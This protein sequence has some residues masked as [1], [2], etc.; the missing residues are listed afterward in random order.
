MRIKFKDYIVRE[1][2][3]AIRIPSDVEYWKKK[4]KRG[5]DCIIFTH[6]D[7]DGIYSAIAM[8]E[9]LLNHGFKISGFGVID[10]SDGWKIFNIDK[11]YINIS[12]DYAE[13]NPDLDIY[14]DHHID[15]D[16]ADY[17]KMFKKMV[18]KADI[19]EKPGFNGDEVSR[20]LKYLEI[21]KKAPRNRLINFRNFYS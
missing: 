21:E 6:N 13:D 8:K 12:V 14:M 7:L 15:D 16:N 2:M 18:V 1:E 10:Y 20:L 17:T 19:K 4:G 3:A 9:Y 11:T 5:K